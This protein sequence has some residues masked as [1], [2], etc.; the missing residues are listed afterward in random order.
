MKLLCGNSRP[1]LFSGPSPVCTSKQ[2][3]ERS[4][5]GTAEGGC[6]HMAFVVAAESGLSG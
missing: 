6:S 2:I 1:R 3:V 4:S 5:R